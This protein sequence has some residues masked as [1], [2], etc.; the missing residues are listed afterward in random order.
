MDINADLTDFFD[1]NA[2]NWDFDA[3]ERHK[4]KIELSHFDVKMKKLILDLKRQD[5]IKNEEETRNRR[6]E[7]EHMD[8]IRK[9]RSINYWEDYKLE[10]NR[11]IDLGVALLRSKFLVKRLIAMRIVSTLPEVISEKMRLCRVNNLY[12]SSRLF[13]MLKLYVYNKRIKKLHGQDF[14]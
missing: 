1:V 11:L 2:N 9:I 13:I 3:I 12:K 14:G 8:R 7:L 6:E 4:S 10:R 5:R